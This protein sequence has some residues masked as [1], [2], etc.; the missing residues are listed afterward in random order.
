MWFLNMTNGKKLENNL[1][2]IW[3]GNCH[4]LVYIAGFKRD[5]KFKNQTRGVGE[6]G[7]DGRY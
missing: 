1:A 6:V 2:D 7:S 5:Q 3:L 4:S